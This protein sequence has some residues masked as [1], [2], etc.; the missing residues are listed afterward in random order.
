MTMTMESD[1]RLKFLPEKNV[2][3][4]YNY[5]PHFGHFFAV[6]NH[7]I[8]NLPWQIQYHRLQC[9]HMLYLCTSKFILYIM[10]IV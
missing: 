9:L 4:K 1:F 6:E 7:K 8:I 3:N 5:L 10:K 2:Q